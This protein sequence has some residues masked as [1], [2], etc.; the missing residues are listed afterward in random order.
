MTST[1]V[2]FSVDAPKP[3]AIRPRATGTCAEHDWTNAAR[4]TPR[5]DGTRSSP[6]LYERHMP[7]ASTARR[8]T[9][10]PRTGVW[11]FWRKCAFAPRDS[12]DAV[13]RDAICLAPLVRTS[14]ASPPAFPEGLLRNPAHSR[15]IPLSHSAGPIHGARP[16]LLVRATEAET[17]ATTIVLRKRG[18]ISP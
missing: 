8:Y 14:N 12:T 15:V 7:V 2:D 11:V 5:V 9:P 18:E 10:L 17:A 13:D 1:S 4:D 6:T 3:W 16:T